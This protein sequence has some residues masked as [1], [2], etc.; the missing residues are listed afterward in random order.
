M[1]GEEEACWTNTRTGEKYCPPDTPQTEMPRTGQRKSFQEGGGV[2]ISANE[3]SDIDR[4]RARQ[5][6]EENLEDLRRVDPDV[7]FQTFMQSYGSPGAV[8][9]AAQT[10]PMDEP[11]QEGIAALPTVQPGG[12]SQSR[13]DRIADQDFFGNLEGNLTSTLRSIAPGSGSDMDG[14]GEW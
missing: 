2:G 8:T 1:K 12:D 10:E 9:P 3:M 13:Y 4:Q 6:Y 5:I 14:T 11:F 7:D